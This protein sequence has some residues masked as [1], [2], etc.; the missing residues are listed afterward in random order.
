MKLIKNWIKRIIDSELKQEREDSLQ[1][2][3]NVDE[4]MRQ[5]PLLTEAIRVT[6]E[7]VVSQVRTGHRIQLLVD[8]AI[9]HSPIVPTGH[10]IK[11]TLIIKDISA[12]NTYTGWIYHLSDGKNNVCINGDS[13]RELMRKNSPANKSIGD[14]SKMYKELVKFE[15]DNGDLEISVSKYELDEEL[16]KILEDSGY[17][18]DSKTSDYFIYKYAPTEGEIYIAPSGDGL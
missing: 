12:N 17:R 3:K 16:I 15:I 18:E 9:N 1:T 11:D 2:K 7:I 6:S 4:V 13:L 5:I 14:F 8:L 10:K